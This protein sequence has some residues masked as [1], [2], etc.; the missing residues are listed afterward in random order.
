MLK[1][2]P[3]SEWGKVPAANGPSLPG[4]IVSLG[5]LSEDYPGF[6]PFNGAMRKEADKNSTADKKAALLGDKRNQG[7]QTVTLPRPDHQP[8]AAAATDELDAVLKRPEGIRTTEIRTELSGERLFIN[9]PKLLFWLPL[10]SAVG[11]DESPYYGF[12]G[13]SALTSHPLQAGSQ[14]STLAAGGSWYPKLG[15]ADAAFYFDASVR[16]G[17]LMFL[18][19]RVLEQNSRTN[20]FTESNSALLSF[21]LPVVNRSFAQN[22][23]DLAVIVAIQGLADRTD[24]QPF[25]ASA[26]LPW[27]NGVTASA[28]LDLFSSLSESTDQVLTFAGTATL[29]ASSFS[30][31]PD[32]VY[33]SGEFTS[34]CYAGTRK[35]QAEAGLRARW[36]DL[37]EGT[38]IPLTLV[39]L[40]RNSVD[41]LYPGRA[42]LEAALVIPGAFNTR[43]FSEKMISFGSNSAGMNTPDGGHPLNLTLDP[44]WFAGLE[45]EAIAGR[46]CIAFGFVNRFRHLDAIELI[47]GSRLY[48][49][50]KLDAMRVHVR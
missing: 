24:A 41:C 32:E 15:Q 38:P 47:E 25:A 16:T 49:S 23:L 33:V 19:Q 4:E 43:F 40:K 5:A 9:T 11:T 26:D 45:I 50:V 34:S 8:D 39:E 30:S 1:I 31:N 2:K 7:K 36:F 10:F 3:D 13:F 22:T 27:R 46:S 28:G 35:V 29:L 37:P 18:G 48:L 6:D 17:T 12:G 21:S 20:A 44:D 14:S 42:I